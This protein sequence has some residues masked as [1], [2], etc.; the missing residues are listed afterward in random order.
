M[1]ASGPKRTL[2]AYGWVRDE[3]AFSVVAEVH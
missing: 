2:S 3:L 1:T